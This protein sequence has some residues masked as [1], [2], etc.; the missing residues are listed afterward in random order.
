MDNE[1]MNEIVRKYKDATNDKK[2]QL[3]KYRP[4]IPNHIIE[5][6]DYNV[7]DLNQITLGNGILVTLFVDEYLDFLEQIYNVQEGSL[8]TE[9][10]KFKYVK[11]Q[12]SISLL[13]ETTCKIERIKR[14]TGIRAKDTIIKHAIEHCLFKEY[15]RN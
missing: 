3:D 12:V 8:E 9:S 2:Q 14:I 11:Q 6:F 13:K 5:L 7:D 1:K 15:M 10:E 4:L